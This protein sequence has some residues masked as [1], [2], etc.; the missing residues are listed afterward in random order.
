MHITIIV[1]I[2]VA[3]NSY[4]QNIFQ[5]YNTYNILYNLKLLEISDKYN[6]IDPYS[7]T[8]ILNYN[9][10]KNIPPLNKMSVS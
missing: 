9:Y 5:G 7:E 10:I 6:S 1:I 4:Y 3:D 2:L 8:T